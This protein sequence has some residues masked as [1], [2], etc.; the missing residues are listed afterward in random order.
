MIAYPQKYVDN[1]SIACASFEVGTHFGIK[2]NGR[3]GKLPKSSYAKYRHLN[4]ENMDWLTASKLEAELLA[5]ADA[6]YFL[7]RQA[8]QRDNG[9]LH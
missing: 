8:K 7:K 9:A 2:H 6:N 1:G 3:V 5:Q 4:E